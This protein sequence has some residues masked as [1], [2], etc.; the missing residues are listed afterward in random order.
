MTLNLT[1]RTLAQEDLDSICAFVRDA[2]EVF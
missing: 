2:E 1:S